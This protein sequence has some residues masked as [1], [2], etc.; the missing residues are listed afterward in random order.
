MVLRRLTP[1]GVFRQIKEREQAPHIVAVLSAD[2][3]DVDSLRLSTVTVIEARFTW[4][5]SEVTWRHKVLVRLV[6]KRDA[7]ELTRQIKQA[8]L[9][10]HRTY[11]FI[12]RKGQAEYCLVQITPDYDG[13]SNIRMRVWH[14]WGITELEPRWLI[15]GLRVVSG[16]VS[17]IG[18]FLFLL[19]CCG[20]ENGQAASLGLMAV[21]FLLGPSL[22]EARVHSL[23]H[24]IGG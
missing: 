12:R 1:E 4:R 17:F 21:V 2:L 22:H 5:P 16:A 8:V 13:E 3:H 15:A 19:L 10:G 23:G 20:L 6:D 18:M 11:C 7:R 14:L 9:T 24:V